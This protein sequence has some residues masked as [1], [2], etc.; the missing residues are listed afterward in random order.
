MQKLFYGGDILTMKNEEDA[1]EAVLVTGG[2][3]AY[4]GTREEAEKLAEAETEFVDL[5]GKTLMPSFIDPHSHIAMYSQFSSFA[6]LSECEDFEEIL[7]VLK[8]YMEEHPVGED[9]AVMARGYD[10]NFLKEETHPT[11]DVLDRVSN[12]IPICLF[13]TSG[14][15]AVANTP[16]LTL[17]GITK[18]TPEPKSGRIGRYEDGTPN[19]YLEEIEVMTPVLML[20]FSRMKQNPMQQMIEVQDIYL[21]YGIT[22]AQDGGATRESVEGFLQMAANRLFKIDV[23]AYV[24]TDEKGIGTLLKEHPEAAGTY[25]NHFQIGGGKII[26]DGSPQGKTAWL[27][28]PYE[29]EETYCGYPT[30]PDEIV[31]G[32]AKAAITGKYQLL[33]HCNGDAASDQYLRCYKKALEET[34]NPRKDLRPVMIHCQTVRDDQL[35]EMKELGMIPSIF[36]AHTYYWGDVHLK[37]LGAERGARISPVKSALERGLP[38]NFHQD[39][40]VLKPDMMQTVWC[41]VNRRTK[42][43]VKIGEEQC[44]SVF[45]ALKGITINAAYAYNEEAKK[46]TIEAGKLADLVILEKNPLKVDKMEIKDIAVAETIK[47]GVT[48]Y[49]KQVYENP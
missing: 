9:G 34:G 5:Q 47:E 41:A 19:G 48:L 24:I 29:G 28:S 18:E 1:P 17:A 13:H 36:V 20:V 4:V 43:G 21:K 14:H 45:D 49:R 31:E 25:T 8:K 15:M 46:G 3:I 11:A 42:K 38:Y 32:A 44:I 30:Y 7:T 12:K 40:P 39:C 26:L 10:H 6:D 37:N 27:T 16:L 23:V 33:A 2:K 22:T 35:D